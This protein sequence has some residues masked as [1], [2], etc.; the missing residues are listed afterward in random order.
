MEEPS[1]SHSC[2]EIDDEINN[3]VG[4]ATFGRLREKSKLKFSFQVILT[5]LLYTSE[6]SPV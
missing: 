2:S 6:T 5:T 1:D 4:G 3:R